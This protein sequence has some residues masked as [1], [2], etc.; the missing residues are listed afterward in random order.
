VAETEAKF[1][2]SAVAARAGRTRL[3]RAVNRRT[4][5]RTVALALAVL[6]VVVLVV[7]PGAQP[8]VE[9]RFTVP[10]PLVVGDAVGTILAHAAGATATAHGRQVTI[11]A[12]DADAGVARAHAEALARAGLDGARQQFATLQTRQVDAANADHARAA[13][14]LAELESHSGLTDPEAAYRARVAVVRN[15]RAELAAAS[16]AGR[17]LGAINAQLAENQQAVFELEL[18]VTRHAELTQAET[19]ATRRRLAAT[20][21]INE[22]G[23]VV[24]AEPIH[25]SDHPTGTT[26][27]I[28][29]GGAALVIAGAMLLVS[30]LRSRR[31]P[32]R[33]AGA[34]APSEPAPIATRDDV[35]LAE[36]EAA[37][38]EPSGRN[39]SRYLDFYRALAPS[40]AQEADA[41]SEPAPVDL[42]HEEA[43]EEHR[44]LEQAAR[45]HDGSRP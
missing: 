32:V 37:A 24:S 3:R 10:I 44:D 43:L 11:V 25:V 23:R 42:V 34:A 22:A 17:P 20:G 14:Q 26:G 21:E 40:Q 36:S 12:T 7:R 18:Q 35:A 1:D 2:G 31:T 27:G 33:S 28:A 16:A 45:E 5:V 13:S 6:G 4:A 29:A 41:D 38:L 30:E 9:A 8:R 15:L 39:A 19:T